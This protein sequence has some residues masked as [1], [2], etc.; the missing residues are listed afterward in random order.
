MKIPPE[1]QLLDAGTAALDEDTQ[2]DQKQDT[3]DNTNDGGI[4]HF[5]FLSFRR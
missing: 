3:G 5:D 1:P 2:H 4:V